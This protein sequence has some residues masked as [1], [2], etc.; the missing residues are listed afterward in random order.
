MESF[1]VGLISDGTSSKDSSHSLVL[2]EHATAILG[3]STAATD[4]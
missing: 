3:T 4:T 1:Y 2:A